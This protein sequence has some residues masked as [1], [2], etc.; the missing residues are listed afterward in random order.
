MDDDRP[1][2]PPRLPGGL[3]WLGHAARFAADPVTF[4]RRGR[5][6]AGDVFS[7]RLLGQ[8]VV[9]V[10]GLAAHATVFRAEESVLSIREA[11]QFLVPVFGRGV[12]YDAETAVMDEQVGFVRPALTSARL[13]TYAAVMAEEAER[14]F[15]AWPDTGTADLAEAMN[16]LTVTIASRCLVGTEFERRLTGELPGLYHDLEA[17]IRLAGLVNPSL[18]LPQFRR[19]DRARE[20][21]TRI[22]VEIVRERRALGDD[23][24]THADLL[25][26]LLA[27]RY[28]DGRPLPDRTIAGVL[29]ALIFAGQ[30]T[31]AVL[32][33][34]AGVLL[35]EHRHHLPAV[36]AEL[37]AAFADDPVV[38]LEKLRRLDLLDR[39]VRE[40]ER[41]H[42]PLV[43]LMRKALRETVVEGRRI[44]PGTLVMLSPGVSH[45]LPELFREPDRYDPARFG[46]GREEGRAPYSLIGFGG[47]RHR[48]PGLAFSYQQVKIIWSVLLRRFDLMLGQ[49]PNPPDY[50]T[51]IVGPRRPCLVHYRRRSGP[52]DPAASGER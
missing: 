38:T 20:R 11:Y 43:L 36:L 39:C 1:P 52:A 23:G 5:D 24:D 2:T 31:S 10:S 42:P 46:P 18:P 16:E 30:H 12:A 28:S 35:L 51:F 21:I 48:C 8:N 13:H 9:F 40:A 49:R 37:D 41:L 26:V 7:F 45:R 34:W 6:R 47:G 29:L 50:S 3:P 27:A 4:L 22:I 44:A 15:G 25:S 14:Y 32:A 19:R 33:T 17:G